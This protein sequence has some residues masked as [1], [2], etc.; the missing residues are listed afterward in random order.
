MLSTLAKKTAARLP[1]GWQQALKRRHFHRQIARDTFRTDEPEWELASRWLSPGDWAI[2]VGA[3][4]GHYSK[5][6]SDLVGPQGRVISFEPVPATFEL[7]AANAARFACANV[8]LINLAAS[9]AT[10]ILSMNVPDFDTGLKNYYAAALTTTASATAL[11]VMSCA[12]DT[13]RLPGPVRML[14]ID[15][16]G[17]DAIV[18]R[19]GKDLITA[20]LPTIVIESS[21]SEVQQFLSGLGYLTESLPGSSNAI[22]RHPSR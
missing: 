20:N 9:D 16:E 2:D 4:I 13:L 21:S 1:H 3:N 8:T 15:A 19:G 6:F 5:R 11:Q 22:Y 7:L 17:H 12:L 10:Q 14:K 18:I